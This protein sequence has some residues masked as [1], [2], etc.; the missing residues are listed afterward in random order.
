MCFFKTKKFNNKKKQ[1]IKSNLF[2]L[3][4]ICGIKPVPV[5]CIEAD[6]E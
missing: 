3:D 6:L 5:V 2:C 1:L 4:L